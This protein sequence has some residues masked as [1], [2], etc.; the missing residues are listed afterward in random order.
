[1]GQYNNR[2]V[3]KHVNLKL[4]LYYRRK[5]CVRFPWVLLKITHAFKKCKLHKKKRY[6]LFTRTVG[7]SM[8]FPNE[9]VICEMISFYEYLDIM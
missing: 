9:G 6:K 2:H 8:K 5:L 4:F 7:K 1:M 3:I